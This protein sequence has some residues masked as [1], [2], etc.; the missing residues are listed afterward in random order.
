MIAEDVLAIARE[1]RHEYEQIANEESFPE[2]LC[3]LCARASMTLFNR[4]R[5]AG[6]KRI[7]L[8]YCLNHVYV[9]VGKMAL[10]ITA[11]Q[12]RVEYKAVH[13]VPLSQWREPVR[14]FRSADALRDYMLYHGWPHEQ[15]MEQS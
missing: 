3:G 7:G 12:F 5:E 6:V 1:V 4:L 2:S 11:T 15:I 13:F 10:D 8:A 9:T 14:R